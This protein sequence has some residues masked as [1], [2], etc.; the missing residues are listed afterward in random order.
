MDIYCFCIVVFISVTILCILILKILLTENINIFLT[1]LCF[2][3]IRI[4]KLL[5]KENDSM[6]SHFDNIS[7]NWEK[8]KEYTKNE[9]LELER[10]IDGYQTYLQD[11]EI[12]HNNTTKELKNKNRYV[13][14]LYNVLSFLFSIYN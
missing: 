2:D 13:L 11:L 14:I 9:I 4:C 7:D 10:R 5:M 8:Q 1:A 3:Y 6:M 12:K